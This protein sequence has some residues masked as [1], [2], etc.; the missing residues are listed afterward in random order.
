[1]SSPA[2]YFMQ[3][4]ILFYSPSLHNSAVAIGYHNNYIFLIYVNKM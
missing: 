4:Y 3:K 1:M 2:D